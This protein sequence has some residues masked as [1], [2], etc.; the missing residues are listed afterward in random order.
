ML[1]V[2]NNLFRFRI[3]FVLIELRVGVQDIPV[4]RE[5]L[6]VSVCI[7]GLVPPVTTAE[8]SETDEVSSSSALGKEFSSPFVQQFHL[9]QGYRA[10]RGIEIIADHF[11]RIVSLADI[12]EEFAGLGDIA[13]PEFA[14]GQG[15]VDFRKPDFHLVRLELSFVRVGVERIFDIAPAAAVVTVSHI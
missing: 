11:S 3:A 1:L 4:Q 5:D 13:L 12:V 2:I 10:L 8:Y 15:I 7:G 14:L 9:I 6:G